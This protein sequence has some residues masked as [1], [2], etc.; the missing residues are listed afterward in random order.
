MHRSIL[1]FIVLIASSAM[2]TT[3]Q[4]LQIAYGAETNAKARYL[5]FAEKADLE[6]YP[7]VASL[8]RAAA[9]AEEI[10]AGNHAELIVKMGATPATTMDALVV[11]S[12][13]ENLEIAIKNEM[14]ERDTMLPEF[15]R[16]ARDENADGGVL[17][18]LN[19]ARAVE[20]EHVKLFIE[21][22]NELASLK[23]VLETYYVCT[24]CGHTTSRLDFEKCADCDHSK[25]S[26]IAVH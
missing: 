7:S 4:N 3:L 19:Y 6:N 12:T 18:T 9:K 22:R 5:A 10:H 2:A 1:L 14:Y 15:L 24:I 23:N 8:F 20:A 26:Y 25:E 16:V 13:A 21:A 17:R 11:K